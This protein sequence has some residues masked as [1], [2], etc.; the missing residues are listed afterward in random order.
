MV[1]LVNN[2]DEKTSQ[3]RQ[4]IQNFESMHMLFVICTCGTALHSC[5]NFALM[6][7]LCTW[8][9]TTVHLHYM[10]MHFFSA[11]QMPV[12]FLCSLSFT[13]ILPGTGTWFIISYVNAW[14]FLRS[15]DIFKP[16]ISTSPPQKKKKKEIEQNKTNRKTKKPNLPMSGQIKQHYSLI[17]AL[18][19]M[20]FALFCRQEL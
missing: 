2:L 1:L 20:P 5:Y 15:Q 12:P 3:R 17:N 18:T 16:A 11:S 10:R 6:L 8:G 4:D 14:T 9:V 7:Q 19:Q 13:L